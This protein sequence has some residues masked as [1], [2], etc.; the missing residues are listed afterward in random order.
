[1]PINPQ[2]G[3]SGGSSI[4]ARDEAGTSYTIADSDADAT[5][6]MTEA[7]SAVSV[8]LPDSLTGNIHVTFVRS[9]AGTLTFV[10][11]GTA[12]IES[13]GGA[14]TIGTQ[15]GAATLIHRGSG[16]WAIVGDLA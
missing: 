1:M 16:V 13:V 10:P 11:Q 9:G 2:T 12:T 4:T 3:G 6:F 7:V 14:D 5:I 8:N 15:Y